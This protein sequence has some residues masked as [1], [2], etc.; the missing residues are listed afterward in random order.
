M[1]KCN[2]LVFGFA[3]DYGIPRCTVEDLKGSGPDYNA[4]ILRRVL[5]GERGPV[6]DSFVS[7][8]LHM[9]YYKFN[10]IYH[11]VCKFTN[12]SIIN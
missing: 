12:G 1:L 3:V 5:A 2:C 8:C 6:A 11:I 9:N 4:E 10:L 7:L